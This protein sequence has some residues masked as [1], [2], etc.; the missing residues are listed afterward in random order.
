M[1]TTGMIECVEDRPKVRPL[2]AFPTEHEGKPV[3][4]IRDPQGL[5]A[6]VAF[7]PHPVFF[8]ITLMDGQHTIL[9]IQEAFVRH[10]GS[11]IF[12]EQIRSLV[13]QL[14]DGLFLDSERFQSHRK[15]LED[16][17]R[18]A[19][20]RKPSHAG[21][22]Y[23]RDPAELGRLLD[24]CLTSGS[25][26]PTGREPRP[27]R[28]VT[29]LVAPHIDFARGGRTYGAAYRALAQAGDAD[30]YV[31]LGV[32]HSIARAFYT[33]TPK[34]FETPLGI[35]KTDADFVRR[36]ADTCGDGMMDEEFAHRGEHSIEFQVLFL[37]HLLPDWSSKRIV[38][39]LCGSFHELLLSGQD[40]W[41]RAELRRFSESLRS[42]LESCGR[43]WALIAA[44]DLAHVGAHFGDE[45]PLS[46]GFL[47]RIRDQD[48]EMLD[49][50]QR[51]DA[52]GLFEHI[53]KDS[54]ER[55]VCGALA[56]YTMLD[57]LQPGAA[58]LL[59]YEQCV[60]QESQACVT[61]AAATVHA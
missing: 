39:V 27:D 7:V 53:R 59:H 42:L 36:L 6:G 49:R 1:K 19:P 41:D 8:L 47:S 56:L 44:V 15:A 29:G 10:F 18:S 2:E 57:V 55:R 22:A 33:L 24:A 43:R 3:I 26:A 14:D 48:L 25:D 12:G 32:G 40:P 58:E 20:L 60:N 54:D 51:G 38:P 16:D 9:E 35:M 50:F 13:Q 30:L 31:I 46:D 17:F 5:A 11:L 61:I 52:R 23:P 28:R 37:Q 45:E 21:A 34:D 4:C